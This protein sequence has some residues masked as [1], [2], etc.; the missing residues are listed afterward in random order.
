[1]II[2]GGFNVYATE[3]EAPI[4]EIEEV[5]ECAVIGVPD[6]RWGEKVTAIV[7]LKVPGSI[8]E[9]NIIEVIKPKLGSVKTLKQFN[10]GILFLK[11]RLGKLIRN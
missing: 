7:V 11:R 2:T 3:V 5:L 6:E 10:F 9:E 8:S 1:M 4:L